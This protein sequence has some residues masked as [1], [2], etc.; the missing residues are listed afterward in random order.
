MDNSFYELFGL[1]SDCSQQ[2]IKKAYKKLALKYH[3]DKNPDNEEAANKF[4]EITQ[5]YEVLSNPQKREI[6]DQFGKDGFDMD[7]TPMDMFAQMFGGGG[8]MGRS[9]KMQVQPVKV[10]VLISLDDSYFGATKTVKYQRKGVPADFV[11]EKQEPPSPELLIDIDETREVILEKGARPGQHQVVEGIGHDIPTLDRGDVV[12]VYVDEKEMR[13]EDTDDEQEEKYLFKRGEDNDLEV[14]FKITLGELYNGVE[15]QL[16]YF[17]KTLNICNYDKI[18][19]NSKYTM[20]GYGIDGGDMNVTFELE[21]PEEI[22]DNVKKNFNSLME[23]L[24]PDHKKLDFSN[25]DAND[26]VHLQEDI[27]GG[28]SDDENENPVQ[29]VQQ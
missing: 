25:L 29:C 11:W 2:D 28:D 19:L 27:F 17:D 3:P 12:F 4:K 18:N 15:R 14:T 6:Y 21:L 10:P 7:D 22:P 13:E 23:K 1:P 8:R 9:Q 24:Y 20:T 26:I 16:K 5:A